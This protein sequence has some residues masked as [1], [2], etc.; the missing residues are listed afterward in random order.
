[1][2]TG[3]FD[4]ELF[5]RYKAAPEGPL[6]RRIHDQLVRQNEPLARVILAQMMGR[7]QPKGKR[8]SAAANMGG[9]LDFDRIEPEDA[10]QFALIALSIALKKLDLSRGKLA[11]QLALW[12]RNELQHYV[13]G[14]AG[15]SLD[16]AR[17]PQTKAHLRP[18][19]GLVGLPAED[20]ERST[21]EERAYFGGE[22]RYDDILES[23]NPPKAERLT[24]TSVENWEE[25]LN[26]EDLAGD[27]DFL[28]AAA[29]FRDTGVMPDRLS[30]L[31]TFLASKPVPP[32]A[33]VPAVQVVAVE[34]SIPRTPL[35]CFLA[36]KCTLA[37]NGHVPRGEL[38]NQF[39]SFCAEAGF[40]AMPRASLYSELGARGVRSGWMWWSGASARA[41]IGL[42]SNC[43]VRRPVV[44]RAARVL[45][46][47][48]SYLRMMRG[49]MAGTPC[50]P[51]I[52]VGAAGATMLT[53]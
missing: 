7:A 52:G 43:S 26:E 8:R 46:E 21:A 51:V 44:R 4:A 40:D 49:W 53:G 2:T 23:E 17:A 33:I 30:S 47:E 29:E 9:R 5:A 1:M 11:W 27:H 16:L 42:R 34:Y 6:K 24:R 25:A 22:A 3:E 36:A 37:P 10:H 41:L 50:V 38:G 15:I 13:T 32:V 45:T 31:A 35:E 12:L 48:E 28:D 39:E 19:V 20:E 18:N 14:S